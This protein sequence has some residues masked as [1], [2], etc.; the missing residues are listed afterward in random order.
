MGGEVKL[1]KGSEVREG[2]CGDAMESKVSRGG[3]RSGT[4]RSER[5]SG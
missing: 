2:K 1:E 5:N 3:M 4:S